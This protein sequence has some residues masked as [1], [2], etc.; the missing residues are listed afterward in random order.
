MIIEEVLDPCEIC[1]EVNMLRP[2]VPTDSTKRMKTPSP[3]DGIEKL[4]KK[5]G[6]QKEERRRRALVE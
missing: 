3:S 6:G 2:R 1:S 5:K 4:V